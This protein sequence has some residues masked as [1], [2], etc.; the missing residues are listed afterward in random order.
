M[1]NYK[2]KKEEEGA[3][4]RNKAKFKENEIVNFMYYGPSGIMQ[5]FVGRIVNCYEA[6]GTYYYDIMNTSGNN[7]MKG[8]QESSIS[9]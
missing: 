3:I 5:S 1:E 9:K 6:N 8:V 7:I 2:N 4:E